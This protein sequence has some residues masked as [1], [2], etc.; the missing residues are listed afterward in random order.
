MAKAMLKKK[1]PIVNLL[2]LY[3]K[4]KLKNSAKPNFFN[5]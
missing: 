4:N 3:A 2:G 5:A 1:M